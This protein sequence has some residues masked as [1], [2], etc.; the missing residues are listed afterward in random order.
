MTFA[1]EDGIGAT[2][3]KREG[4]LSFRVYA[5]GNWSGSDLPARFGNPPGHGIPGDLY[6]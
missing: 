4:G 6:A 1:A 5:V 2:T 3:P